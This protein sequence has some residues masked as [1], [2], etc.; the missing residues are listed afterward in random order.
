MEGHR[1]RRRGRCPRR[2]LDVG[3]RKSESIDG[4]FKERRLVKL[5]GKKIVV[6]VADGFEDLEYW[7]TVMRLREEGAEVISVGP[8][9]GPFHGK[10]YLEARADA[11]ANDVDAGE[12]D[13]IVIPGGWA[14][15]KLRRYEEVT[16]L[17]AAVHLESSPLTGSLAAISAGIVNGVSATGS[18]GIK[19][20]LVNAGATWVDKPAFRENNL[21][22]G[23]VVPDIPDFCRE[24]VAALSEG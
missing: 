20:Y 18:L 19:D 11:T 12:L 1:R 6:L 9:E 7:V 10:N 4:N 2:K 21:V 8:G 15:D 13:G 3:P 24:L 23:R 22:W 16:D 14:P 17:V 5:R